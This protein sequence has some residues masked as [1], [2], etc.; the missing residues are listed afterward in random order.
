MDNETKQVFASFGAFVFF[1]VFF[2]AIVFV[3][4][5]FIIKYW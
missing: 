4:S 2:G 5:H 1:V 3:A